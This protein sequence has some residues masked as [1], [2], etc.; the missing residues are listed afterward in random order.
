MRVEIR[1]KRNEETFYKNRI[2]IPTEYSEIMKYL[3]SRNDDLQIPNL[4][5]FIENRS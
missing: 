3:E 5:E 4:K 2:L 1:K